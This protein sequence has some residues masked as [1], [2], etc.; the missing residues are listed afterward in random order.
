MIISVNREAT[1]VAGGQKLLS[2][3]FY[4]GNVSGSKD[5]RPFA[6]RQAVFFFEH[7]FVCYSV[8]SFV[9]YP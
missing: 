9:I 3:A 4:C 5:Q 1:L 6:N 7:K 2:T 8:I